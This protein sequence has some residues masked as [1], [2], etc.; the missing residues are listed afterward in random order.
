MTAGPVS[1]P[2]ETPGTGRCARPGCPRPVVRNPVGR[3]RLYCSPPC[4]AE[5]HRQAHPASREPSSSKSTTAAPAAGAGPPVTSGWSGSGAVRNRPSSPSASASPPRTTWT[6]RF[7][8]SLTPHPWPPQRASG[9]TSN[10]GPVGN[11][12]TPRPGNYVT[13][14]SRRGSGS[15]RLSHTEPTR[16]AKGTLN[17]SDA[18]NSARRRRRGDA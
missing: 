13:V 18:T 2:N 4:R 14:D 17:G 5:A 1:L 3:P 8:T 7:A 11:Y 9:R 16:P 15:G 10:R 12:V 6:P